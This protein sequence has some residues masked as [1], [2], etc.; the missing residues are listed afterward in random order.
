MREYTQKYSNKNRKNAKK[1]QYFVYDTSAQ[2]RRV[3]RIIISL[4][5]FECS[6]EKKKDAHFLII[7]QN[8]IRFIIIIVVHRPEK[9]CPG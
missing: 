4:S 6:T 7:K 2:T 8:N 9:T 5:Y 1:L 3:K